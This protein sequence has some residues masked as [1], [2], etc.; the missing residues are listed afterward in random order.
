MRAGQGKARQSQTRHT[1]AIS[2]RVKFI[3][4]VLLE[5]A[6]IAGPCGSWPTDLVT[7][8]LGVRA[9]MGGLAHAVDRNASLSGW[10][11]SSKAAGRQLRLSRIRREG[12]GGE[13][14][15]DTVRIRPQ[16]RVDVTRLQDKKRG[17]LVV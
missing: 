16:L 7:G 10:A 2:A 6:Q 8:V 3:T 13:Q 11:A 4:L 5:T 9:R 15:R 1:P 12:R 14:E 17:L